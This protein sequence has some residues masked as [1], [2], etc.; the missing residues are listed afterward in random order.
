VFTGGEPLGP[1]G[2]LGASDFSRL[3]VAQMA[4]FYRAVDV[5]R[6]YLAA[7]HALNAV[8][9]SLGAGFRK[10]EPWVLP[11]SALFFVCLGIAAGGL[12]RAPVAP[13]AAEAAA[14]WLLVASVAVAWL[15]LAAV[16]GAGKGTRRLLP[17]VAGSGLLA[18]AG[19]QAGPALLRGALLEAAAV[20][21]LLGMTSRRGFRAYLVALVLSA[22]GTLGGTMA[23]EHGATAL[24]ISLLLPGFA[25]K[26][27]LAPLCLWLPAVAEEEPA[28]LGGLVIAVV[29][30]AALAELIAL[31]P[32]APWL[33]TPGWPWITLGLLSAVLGAL[34]ALGTSHLKR[35]LAFSTIVDMGALALALTLG[36]RLG[37]E[38]A[39]LGAAVHALAKSLL[40]IC[41]SVP[42]AA[43]A[44]LEGARALAA[45]HP[46][47]A[48]GF[49]VGALSV[50]GVPPTLGFAV[51]WRLFGTAGASPGLLAALAAVTM[52]SIAIY[53]RAV[54]R[55]WWG[56]DG[57]EDRTVRSAPVPAAAILVLVVLLLALGVGGGFAWAR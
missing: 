5:D 28:L 23:A 25:I 34:L 38:A 57:P 33:F 48:A 10:L 9:A 46:L 22:L 1:Q 21:A 56:G 31:R 49:L 12:A 43:G 53:A 39:L 35:L 30:V 2:R 14:P 4:P 29:D 47:A 3:L 42:E 32:A 44:R 20:A 6:A 24:A 37:L 17:Y 41:V 45:E 40:F 26:L 52:L 19:M 11:L 13:G 55:F 7:W 16:A 51:H 54:A 27:G 36:G 18:L 8:A 50:V 15:A